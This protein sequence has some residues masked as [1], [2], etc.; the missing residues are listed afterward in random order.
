[1]ILLKDKDMPSFIL[2]LIQ[3]A[4]WKSSKGSIQKQHEIYEGQNLRKYLLFLASILLNKNELTKTQWVS[5]CI[6]NI[7]K[8]ES[9]MLYLHLLEIIS[10]KTKFLIKFKNVVFDFM[11]KLLPD[12]DNDSQLASIVSEIEKQWI[13]I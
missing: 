7:K 6:S 10:L 9:P 3:E 2:S 12:N 4:E 11:A 8:D 5:H 13:D 1:M